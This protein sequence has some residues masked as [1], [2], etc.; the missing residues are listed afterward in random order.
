MP[1]SV[2]RKHVEIRQVHFFRQ[3]SHASRVFVA[4][5][6]HQQRPALRSVPGNCGPMA[7]DQL[8]AV[9]CGEAVRLAGTHAEILFRQVVVSF[10]PCRTRLTMVYSERAAISSNSPL[11]QAAGSHPQATPVARTP[12]AKARSLLPMGPS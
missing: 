6:K 12:K 8:L 1:A 11:S 7:V 3:M 10:N 2:P 5:V 9:M 4:A